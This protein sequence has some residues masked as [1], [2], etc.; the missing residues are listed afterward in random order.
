LEED[1]SL[2]DLY[3]EVKTMGTLKTCIVGQWAATLSEE[4]KKALDL[5]I[6]DDDLSTKDLF[7]LLRRAGGT[8]G[9]TAVRDHRQGDCVC[10]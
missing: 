6:E 5:A 2:Q 7:L 4:D 3:A 8:F 1:M 9:K 10:L